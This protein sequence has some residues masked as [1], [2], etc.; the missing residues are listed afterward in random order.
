MRG[1]GG[2]F[3]GGKRGERKIQVTTVARASYF[4]G[5]FGLFFSQMELRQG[6]HWME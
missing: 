3:Y 6:R 1:I 2:G 5:E 4:L